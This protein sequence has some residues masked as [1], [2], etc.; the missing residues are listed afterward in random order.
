VVDAL[1]AAGMVEYVCWHVL[2]YTRTKP[3]TGL[4]SK[5]PPRV[6]MIAPTELKQAADERRS[7]ILVWVAWSGA[8]RALGG[9]SDFCMWR[10][11]GRFPER[12]SPTV[13][14]LQASCGPE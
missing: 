7:V 1:S 13:Q 3:R 5:P 4:T 9:R 10:A 2:R 6:W 14:W 11:G 12:L 8:A